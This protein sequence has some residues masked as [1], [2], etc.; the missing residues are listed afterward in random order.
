M[1]S[2]VTFEDWYQ[3]RAVHSDAEVY[4]PVNF[5]NNIIRFQ[6]S[7]IPDVDVK[8]IK[9][10][11]AK[12]YAD[13]CSR[14]LKVW[15]SIFE[16]QLSDCGNKR[17]YIDNEISDFLQILSINNNLN[18][19]NYRMN[20]INHTS[21]VFLEESLYQIRRYFQDIVLIDKKRDYFFIHSPLSPVIDSTKIPCEIYAQVCWDYYNWLRKL[22][23]K[24]KK[25]KPEELVEKVTIKESQNDTLNTIFKENYKKVEIIVNALKK[26]NITSSSSVR[27]I[28]AFIDVSKQANTLPQMTNV[29]LIRVIFNELQKPIP[30]SLK[31]RAD[32]ADYKIMLKATKKYFG[33]I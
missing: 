29:K 23:I 3:G 7:D 2:K 30:N 21:L 15:K 20:F 33:L 32:G 31:S 8:K 11:Q 22:K 18:T 16:S 5:K 19:I 27:Q 4:I 17:R 6:W 12:I 14:I 1:K 28:T 26:L 24:S 10:F 25:Y 13:E 9:A